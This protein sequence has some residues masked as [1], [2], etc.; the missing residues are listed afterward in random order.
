MQLG[1]YSVLGILDGIGLAPGI[2]SAATSGKEYV[3]HP[4][5]G[6]GVGLADGLTFSAFGAYLDR[7]KRRED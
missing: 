7:P 5:Q 1:R 2:E 4:L 3:S 6:F